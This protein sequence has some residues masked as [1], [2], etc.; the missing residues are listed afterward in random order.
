MAEADA[1]GEIFA[2]KS[3]GRAPINF[4]GLAGPPPPG[5]GKKTYFDEEGRALPPGLGSDGAGGTGGTGTI[6]GGSEESNKSAAQLLKERL[7]GGKGGSG[8]EEVAAGA[9]G[10]LAAT[11]AGNGAARAGGAS[12][13]A[14][15]GGA[16]NKS[17]A[18]LLRE[19]LKG[20]WVEDEGNGA[21]GG[22]T[23]EA[24]DGAGEAAGAGQD[25]VSG[26]L[27][28]SVPCTPTILYR[29]ADGASSLTLLW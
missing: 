3:K 23:P 21:M 13:G 16:S 20:I 17:A 27:C 4:K 1:K 28:N 29:A 10:E 12:A 19:R 2:A 18:Q 6:G 5:S 22:T 11:A 24:A 15:A 9:G 7:M 14:A 8:G 25:S 26:L